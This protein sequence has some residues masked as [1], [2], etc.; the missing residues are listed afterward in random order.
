MEK[1][2]VAGFK[3]TW[4]ET[5]EVT[6]DGGFLEDPELWRDRLPQPFR[7]LDRLLEDILARAWE[8][9]ATRRL[10]RESQPARPPSPDSAHLLDKYLPQETVTEP[11]NVAG[12]N[13]IDGLQLKLAEFNA[14]L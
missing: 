11:R 5:E 9:I 8:E 12:Y 14:K 3:E 6:G 10:Q 4:T 1:R 13:L 2:L 7:M